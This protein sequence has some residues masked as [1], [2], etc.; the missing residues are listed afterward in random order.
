MSKPTCR[1]RPGRFPT[2]TLKIA[3]LLA[4]NPILPRQFRGATLESRFCIQTTAM[5][6][7]REAREPLRTV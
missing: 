6:A 4:V 7:S 3:A 5:R 1:Q 2:N